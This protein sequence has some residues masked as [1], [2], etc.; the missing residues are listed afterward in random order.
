MNEGRRIVISH[1][2]RKQ[3]LEVFD[4]TYPTVRKALAFETNSAK[5]YQIQQFALRNG[6]VLIGTP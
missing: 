5:A 4:T 3:I 6:G 1:A 2:L